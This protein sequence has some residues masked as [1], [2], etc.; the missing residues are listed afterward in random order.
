MKIGTNFQKILV[1]I[2]LELLVLPVIGEK[3]TKRTLGGDEVAPE[4]VP[5]IVLINGICTGTLIHTEWVLTAAH[6]FQ[7]RRLFAKITYVTTNELYRQHSVESAQVYL[8]PRFRKRIILASYDLALIQL[9]KPIK[10]LN[11]VQLLAVDNSE[12]PQKDQYNR[13]CNVIGFGLKRFNNYTLHVS[14]FKAKH[15]ESACRCFPYKGVICVEDMPNDGICSG[16]SGAPMICD[17]K[18]VGVTSASF[19]LKN[20]ASSYSA[21]NLKQNQTNGC[22]QTQEL[23]LFTFLCPQLNWIKLYVDTVPSKPLSCKTNKLYKEVNIFY[24]LVTVITVRFLN[25]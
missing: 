25:N 18:L 24:Q 19:N 6:C 8:H 9:V 21:I 12:W 23:H 22:G 3:R 13:M 7:S 11:M 2:L 20:C 17:G 1:Y 10:P 5:F 14:K 16:D 4:S 15:G